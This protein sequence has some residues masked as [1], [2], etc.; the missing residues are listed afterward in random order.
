MAMA[1]VRFTVEVFLMTTPALLYG[2]RVR[3]VGF[4]IPSAHF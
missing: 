4:E 3:F 1:T 2:F